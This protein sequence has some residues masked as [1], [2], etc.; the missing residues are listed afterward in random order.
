MSDKMSDKM[1]NKVSEQASYQASEKISEQAS[2]KMSDKLKARE[3]VFLE[4]LISQLKEEKYVT[5][6]GLSNITSIPKPAIRRYMKKFCELGIL[7]SQGKNKSTQYRL[8]KN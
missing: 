6:T 7:V 2:D 8:K 1:P 3:K 5:T 4:I